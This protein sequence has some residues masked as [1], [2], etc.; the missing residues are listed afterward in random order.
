MK[1]PIGLISK[2]PFVLFNLICRPHIILRTSHIKKFLSV[3]I[4]RIQ[5][6]KLPICQHTE[7]FVEKA[8]IFTS[9]HTNIYIVLKEF[10]E[11]NSHEHFIFIFDRCFF[12]PWSM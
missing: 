1:G 7:Y 9:I 12:N 11:S 8:Y 4:A 2:N 3:N 6:W 5:Y 10:E